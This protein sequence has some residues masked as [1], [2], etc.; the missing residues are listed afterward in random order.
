MSN[1][2]EKRFYTI[3]EADTT[4]MP[5]MQ[6]GAPGNDREAM[7]Q[8]LKTT[9]PEDFDVE[10]PHGGGELEREKEHQKTQLGGWVQEI[11]KFITFLNGTDGGS[12][13]AKLHAARCDSVFEDI[14]RSEKKKIA[15]IAAE[16][17]SLSEA[18][19]GYLISMSN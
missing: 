11:D 15:R 6:D 10:V 8:T 19:K 7:A 5:E 12:I 16:L 1:I 18:F 14:A 4:P 2:F 3:L 13:Q 17:S 9:K